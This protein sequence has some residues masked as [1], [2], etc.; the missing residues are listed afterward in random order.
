MDF[1]G[2][3]VAVAVDWVVERER[4]EEPAR[5]SILEDPTKKGQNRR[6]MRSRWTRA[7]GER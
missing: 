5:L 4:G 7:K 2:R 3:E 6:R 1:A